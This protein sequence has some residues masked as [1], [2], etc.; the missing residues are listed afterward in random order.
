MA[1]DSQGNVSI[2]TFSPLSSNSFSRGWSDR[3]NNHHDL[4]ELF[5]NPDKSDECDP[6]LMLSVPYSEYTSLPKFN[7]IISSP[8]T[9]NILHCNIRSLPE[10]LNLLEEILSSLNTKPN[11]LHCN[12]RS[13]PKNLNL[14]EEILSSLNTKPNIIGITETK[15]NEFSTSN[16]DIESYNFF[17][18]DSS[19]NAG[20]AAL[21]VSNNL[22]TSSRPHIKFDMTSVESCWC[23]IDTSNNKKPIIVGCIYRHPNSD[24]AEFTAQLN[25]IIQ[26]LNPRFQIY[27]LGDF[28][29]DFLKANVHSLTEEYLD[30]LFTNGILPI[31]TKATRITDHTA[32]LIDHIYTN[33]PI[34]QLVSGIL[35][36]D[37][38][39]HLPVIC[40]TRMHLDKVSHKQSFRDFSK[41]NKE[42]FLDDINKINW[43]NILQPSKTLNDKTKDAIDIIKNLVNKHAPIKQASQSKQKQ[44]N[45]PWITAGILKSIKKKQKMHVPFTFSQQKSRENK[46]I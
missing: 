17:H 41:F 22:K 19:T 18:K 26:D 10:N 45:R 44:L 12:I 4:F 7:Q 28:N 6:D 24:L 3:L 32:T 15:L 33:T 9:F 25:N 39:D 21:Y 36:V 37:V 11:I 20:G 27:I 29:I 14:L 16:V 5:S 23:Q 40:S 31:I 38:S 1:A 43:E 8:Q 35:T 34:P 13:L 2:D 46:N 42:Q 30:M